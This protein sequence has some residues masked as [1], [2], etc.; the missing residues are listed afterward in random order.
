MSQSVIFV[1]YR[2]LKG[3]VLCQIPFA[4]VFQHHPGV[5]MSICEQRDEEERSNCRRSRRFTDHTL[6]FVIL[7]LITVPEDRM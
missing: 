7:Q 6:V 2:M 5:T 1:V 3:L 4:R